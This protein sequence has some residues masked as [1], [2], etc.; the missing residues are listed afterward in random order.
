MDRINRLH[1]EPRIVLLFTSDYHTARLAVLVE[2]W[3]VIS[4]NTIVDVTYLWQAGSQSA[5]T[6]YFITGFPSFHIYV[7]ENIISTQNSYCTYP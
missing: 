5:Y 4:I 3:R 6:S 1:I 2:G 7:R